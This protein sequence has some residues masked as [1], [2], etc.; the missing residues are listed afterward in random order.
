[1]KIG[2]LK[3]KSN[4]VLITP[5][6]AKALVSQGHI[7]Y[8]TKDC[9]KISGFLNEDYIA[10]G[11]KITETNIETIEESNLL[12]AFKF[13]DSDNLNHFNSEKTLLTYSNIVSNSE[14][15]RLLSIN[16][17]TLIGIEYIENNG[18]RDLAKKISKLVSKISFNM[19]SYFHN[20][21]IDGSGNII[22]NLPYIEKTNVTILGCGFVGKELLKAFS[23]KNCVVSVFDKNFDSFDDLEDLRAS[24]F[25]I[26]DSI[27]EKSLL[28]SDI[29]I[30]TI[31]NGITPT[32]KFITADFVSKMKKNSLIF[33]LSINNGGTFETSKETTI[34]NPL[35]IKNG[36]IHCCPSDVLQMCAKPLSNYLSNSI[37]NYILL[38][39][40]GYTHVNFF[41]NALLIEDGNIKKEIEFIEDEKEDYSI[42]TNPFDLM[43]AE[44][45]Q[46]WKYTNDIN[47]FNDLLDEIDD[48][49]HDL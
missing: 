32:K 41:K 2:I 17:S 48:Y 35:Y 1:M 44:V 5:D 30:S 49:E 23:T 36:V 13:P 33:D 9:A 11:A 45:S 34:N 38:I 12:T 18:I 7:V 14:K 28:E 10:C 6:T 37:L 24:C 3:E 4:R 19:I 39:A 31:S 25:N 16:N 8:F 20:K 29:V 47:D 26:N 40:E 27:L 22:E 46:S 21:P 15:A 43:D 42:L